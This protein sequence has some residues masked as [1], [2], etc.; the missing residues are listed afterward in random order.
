MQTLT[1]AAEKR[2]LKKSFKPIMVVI[3]HLIAEKVYFQV[4]LLCKFLEPIGERLSANGY[5]FYLS[6]N[7]Y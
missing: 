4:R 5:L 6:H 3:F 1:N 2:R 7:L